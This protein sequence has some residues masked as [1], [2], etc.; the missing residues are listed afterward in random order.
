MN[1]RVIYTCVTGGYESIVD[2]SFVSPNFDYICF[3]DQE[4]V[5]SRVW[6]IRPIPDELKDLS[7]IKQQRVIKICPHLFLSQ[8]ESSIY[9]DGSIDM[10]NDMN[11]FLSQY[12]NTTS[13]TQHIYA[14]SVFIR[15]H[16]LRN[17]IYEEASACINLGKDKSSV[18]EK[19]MNRYHS[20]SY[21]SQNGLV[22]SGIIYRLHNNPY[23]IQLMEMWRDEVIRDSHRDQLSFNYCL[24]KVGDEG[25]QYINLDLFNNPYFKWYNQHDR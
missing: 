9:V 14:K 20:Q 23:C 25:F 21:P 5:K 12:C 18:I 8:Y 7:P 19:Q 24:W 1:K 2:P 6:S 17:C 4:N 3:T 15:K 10:K 13:E 16:P 11:I 22:E